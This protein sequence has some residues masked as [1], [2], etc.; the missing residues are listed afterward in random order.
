M[1]GW[2][3]QLV[4]LAADVLSGRGFSRWIRHIPA[5]LRAPARAA[6]QAT[7]LS[8][9]P[10]HACPRS[11]SSAPILHARDAS[12]LSPRGPASI[13]ALFRP[14]CEAISP[15]PARAALP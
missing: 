9:N 11:P 13:H 10:H 12:K 3:R 2:C 6:G 4:V 15:P 7:L 8:L 1:V 5:P 14:H